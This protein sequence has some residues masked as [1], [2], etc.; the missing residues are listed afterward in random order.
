VIADD[1]T[2]DHVALVGSAISVY[3][4]ES[5]QAGKPLLLGFDRRFAARSFACHLATHLTSQ[6]QA[7]ILAAEPTPT[8]AIAFGVQHLGAAGAV[9]LTASHNPYF[10]QGLKFIPYFAGPAMPETTDR[11]TALIH[12]LAPSFTPPPLQLDWNGERVSLKQ[13]YFA[14]LD[15]VVN[16]ASL[17]SG[18][19]RVLF[20]P[21]HGLGAGWLDGYL[22][23]AGVNVVTMHASRDVYFGDSL[24]ILARVT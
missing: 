3:L 22:E 12:D 20:D 4:Q 10:W 5:G 8:P 2:F 13:D 16:S 1:F 14:Q 17:V 6:G 15:T 24:P 9:M 18:S 11:I 7:A 21:M 19:F 23:R